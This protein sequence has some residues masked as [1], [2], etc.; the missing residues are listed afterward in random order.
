MGVKSE[1]EKR[2]RK[3][4]NDF[5]LKIVFSKSL[6]Y[7]Y[8]ISTGLQSKPFM[9]LT[10]FYRPLS[11]SGQPTEGEGKELGQA[12]V[13]L[14]TFLPLIGTSET[15]SQWM[16]VVDKVKGFHLSSSFFCLFLLFFFLQDKEVRGIIQLVLRV[17][18]NVSRSE[19]MLPK[20][21]GFA[22]SLLRENIG[23][24]MVRSA[25]IMAEA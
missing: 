4:E 14:T 5:F 3:K 19:R 1:R 13:P 25:K 23:A 22:K 21:T 12:I 18:S 6:E 16:P 24:T 7:A 17:D 15:V 20:E 2:E 9:P 10:V 11:K 8:V